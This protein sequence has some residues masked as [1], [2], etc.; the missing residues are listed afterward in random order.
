MS[1]DVLEA[2]ALAASV[3]L[4]L[5]KAEPHAAVAAAG[6]RYELRPVAAETHFDFDDGEEI[7]DYYE[8]RNY[9]D[10]CPAGSSFSVFGFASFLLVTMQTV[11]NV[12]NSKC[13]SGLDK[14]I[15]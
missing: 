9:K 3:F 10:Y 6:G 8:G 15:F 7:Y 5:V 11:L 1:V 2:M 14:E 4:S 13:L 12:V